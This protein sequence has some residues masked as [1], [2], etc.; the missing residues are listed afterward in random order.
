M[1]AYIQYTVG[2]M[3][4]RVKK[5]YKCSIILFS[6]PFA[7][8]SIHQKQNVRKK[9]HV[10]HTYIKVLGAK[11]D[12]DQG[13]RYGANKLEKRFYSRIHIL[14]RLY[15]ELEKKIFPLKSEIRR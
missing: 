12:F 4:R 3:E 6:F 9:Q 1:Y 2:Q 5:L 10:L 7:A 13:K 11:T 8:K 15:I 14:L